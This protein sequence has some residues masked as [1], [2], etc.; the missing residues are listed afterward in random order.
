MPAIVVADAR[1]GGITVMILGDVGG[2]G[3]G[4]AP[5]SIL[6]SIA[7]AVSENHKKTAPVMARILGATRP[8]YFSPDEDAGRR[9]MRRPAAWN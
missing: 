2:A 1:P 9:R 5:H 7:L 4:G 8:S 6:R 3:R